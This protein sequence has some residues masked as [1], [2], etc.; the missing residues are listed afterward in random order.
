MAT[1]TNISILGCGWLG[2]PLAKKL[3][4]QGYQVKGSTTSVQKLESFTNAR[5]NPYV[6]R[7]TANTTEGDIKNFIANSEILIVAIPPG[8]R[9]ENAENFPAKLRTFLSHLKHSSIKNILFISSTSVYPDNNGIALEESVFMPDNE[10]G[11]QLLEA[12][13]LLKSAFPTTVLRFGGLIA[14]DRHPIYHLSGKVNIAH[15]DAPINLIHRDDCI[16]IIVRIIAGQIW[17]E[18]FNAVTPFHPTRKEYYKEVAAK[19]QLPSPVFNE[20]NP[21]FGKQVGSGKLLRIMGYD[22]IHPKL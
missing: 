22:F 9:K 20:E 12:E 11:K 2:F 10:G 6:I 3:V 19:L 14:D 13:E 5:I 21:S 1:K 18:T 7:L 16:S 8:L 4:S 15:P 17:D